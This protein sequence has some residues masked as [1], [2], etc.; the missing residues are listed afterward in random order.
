[1]SISSPA[2]QTP[3]FLITGWLGSGKTTLLNHILS[4]ANGKKYAVLINE[5]GELGIDDKLIK[6]EKDGIIELSNGCVCCTIRGDL[7]EK[8]IS[9]KKRKWPLFKRPQYDAVFIETTGLA[10]PAPLLRTF[11][12]EEEVAS[13]FKV[14]NIITV[15]DSK[16]FDAAMAHSTAVEQI[17]LADIALIN[18]KKT[19]LEDLEE[20][21]RGI[22]PI[23]KI[24]VNDV[25]EIDTKVLIN[26]N[27][28]SMQSIPTSFK[29]N[30][31]D[32]NTITLT[33]EIPSDLLKIQ[34]WL[35][36][37]VLNLGEDLIRYKGFLHI[38]EYPYSCLL[39]GV[40][41]LYEVT[42]HDD[43]PARPCTEIVFIGKNLD[44]DFLQKGLVATL[45]I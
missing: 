12:V 15:I 6:N 31:H 5:F 3:V 28:S 33:S 38:K 17:S 7:A 34:L 16:N 23:A 11:L 24:L 13:W 41:D 1:M 26:K 10:E 20:K 44:Y 25:R 21:V 40:Y 35:D 9:L 27:N 14:Q 32:L 45:A 2:S 4:K 43:W 36:S 30:A 19:V 18:N 42:A 29:E 39:Q 37:C 8:M 22:N